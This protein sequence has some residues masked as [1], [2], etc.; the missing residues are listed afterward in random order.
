MISAKKTVVAGFIGIV[1]LGL[2]MGV[3]NAGVEHP[4][5]GL[6]QYGS[7]TVS[8]GT[9][10][11]SMYDHNDRTHSSAVRNCNGTSS[12]GWRPAGT[13]AEARQN[14]CLTGNEAFYDV[15]GG[16]SGKANI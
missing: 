15:Q 4:E 7:S 8:G 10:N 2:G 6:W 11:Y 9:D 12:S 16:S 13:R 1:G 3:G 5:G 14:R